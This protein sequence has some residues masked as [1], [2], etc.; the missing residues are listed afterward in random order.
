[1]TADINICRPPVST[2]VCH[3]TEKKQ[4]KIKAPTKIWKC[5]TK[6]SQNTTRTRRRLSSSSPS[7]GEAR[8]SSEQM[9]PFF[10]PQHFFV[11]FCLDYICVYVPHV[12][13]VIECAP[14]WT[15]MKILKGL[16]TA[17]LKGRPGRFST[18]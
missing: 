8:T 10:F 9:C 11:L 14:L 12:E 7:L 15:L 18:K 3:G 5:P 6:R 13:C 17:A 2:R 16:F 4:I 1:M